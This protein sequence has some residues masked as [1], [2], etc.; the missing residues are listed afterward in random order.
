VADLSIT[1]SN[2]INTFGI[3]PSNKWNEFLWG[4]NWGYG[5]TDLKT[6]LSHFLISEAIGLADSW[7]TV[8]TFF[9]T[10]ANTITTDGDASEQELTDG[11]GYNYVFTRPTIDAETRAN[12]TF[13]EVEGAGS[14]WSEVSGTSGGWT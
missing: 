14:S 13:S 4:E 9:K 11:S 10:F 6:E 1:I 2:Q 8:V 5:N 3:E 12:T 7:S